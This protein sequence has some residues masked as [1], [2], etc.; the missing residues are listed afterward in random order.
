MPQKSQK[1][2]HRFKQCCVTCVYFHVIQAWLI[3]DLPVIALCLL[4]DS[5]RCLYEVRLLYG[6][7]VS[8]ACF[9]LTYAVFAVWP[10][11]C[12]WVFKGLLSDLCFCFL[13]FVWFHVFGAKSERCVCCTCSTSDSATCSFWGMFLGCSILLVVPFELLPWTFAFQNA[14][15]T[16]FV[17]GETLWHWIRPSLVWC[18]LAWGDPPESASTPT[19]GRQVFAPKTIPGSCWSCVSQSFHETW[20]AAVCLGPCPLTSWVGSTEGE[21]ELDLS[22]IANVWNWIWMGWKWLKPL[23]L[24]PRS[25]S[26]TS[27]ADASHARWICKSLS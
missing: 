10:V 18:I 20:N 22:D 5:K 2:H 25:G 23:T 27:L 7:R 16:D 14:N 13:F 12:L 19:V 26:S 6:T 8:F 1:E 9:H 11:W 3:N 21:T 17:L 4:R 24:K 15:R